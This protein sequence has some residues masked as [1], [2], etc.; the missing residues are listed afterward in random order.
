MSR[1]SSVSCDKPNSK[2]NS[3]SEDLEFDQ[4]IIFSACLGSSKFQVFKAQAPNTDD[5]VAV[6]IFPPQKGNIH[7]SF[8]QESKFSRLQHDNV[9]RII[10]NNDHFT[11]KYQEFSIEG[12]AIIM[13]LA[14]C[15]MVEI[16]DNVNLVGNEKL[17]RTL[18][19][20]IVDGMAYIHSQGVC[21]LDLKPENLLLGSDFKL[22]IADFDFSFDKKDG[23]IVGRGTENY[24]APE[25]KDRTC[26]NPFASDIYSLGIVLFILRTKIFPFLE[27]KM[28][29]G[30]D[31]ENLAHNDIEAF[32][33]AHR[34]FGFQGEFS[35]EF[36]DLFHGMVRKDPADRISIKEVKQSAWLQG[37]IYTPK[38]MRALFN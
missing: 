20:N 33:D 14:L 24:R 9:I 7:P 22:K 4:E 1:T 28:V 38:E 37:P 18:F 35:Q 27:G 6:K 29:R 26:K 16:I 36:I 17:V 32:F 5:Q 25:I 23:K 2:N 15:D 10:E 12:S 30:Y 3:F 8:I 13:E 31:L 19:K 11:G 34:S 21:H